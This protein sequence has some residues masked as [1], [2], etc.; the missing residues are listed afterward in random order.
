MFAMGRELHGVFSNQEVDP[1][2]ILRKFWARRL[3]LRNVSETLVRKMLYFEWH[4]QV[5]YCRL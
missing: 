1:S 5:L 2:P 3:G 4:G